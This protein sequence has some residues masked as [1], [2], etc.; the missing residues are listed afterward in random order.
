M[1]L[2]HALA[3]SGTLELTIGLGGTDGSVISSNVMSIYVKEAT[4]ILLV[5]WPGDFHLMSTSKASV[6]LCFVI[7]M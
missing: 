1:M 5:S 6:T 3:A 7:V 2:L 4:N